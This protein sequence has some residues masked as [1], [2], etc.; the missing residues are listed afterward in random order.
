M[1]DA[2]ESILAEPYRPFYKVFGGQPILVKQCVQSSLHDSLQTL[3]CRSEIMTTTE[4]HLERDHGLVCCC[5]IT[6]LRMQGIM[7]RMNEV[8]YESMKVRGDDIANISYSVP[9]LV[10]A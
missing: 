10:E 9:V 4:W 6:C 2:D 1:G 5:S 7:L 3:T 8:C